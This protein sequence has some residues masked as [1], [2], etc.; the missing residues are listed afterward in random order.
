[1]DAVST[2]DAAPTLLPAVAPRGLA[3]ATIDRRLEFIEHISPRD[4]HVPLWRVPVSETEQVR[5]ASAAARH[6]LGEW[7]GWPRERR[8]ELLLTVAE[9][10]AADAPGLV[11]QIAIETGKPICDARQE[12][13]FAIALLRATARARDDADLGGGPGW[14]VRRRPQGVVAMITPWNN[15]LAIP[16]GKL[17]P[18]LLHGNTVVWKP[19]PAGAAVALQTLELLHQAGLPPGTVTLVQGNHVTAERLIADPTVDAVT[20]TGSSAAGR[21]AQR[22]CVARQVPF[23]GE[24]GGNNPAIV[25]SDANLADAAAQVAQGGFGSAGQRCTAN[26]RVIVDHDCYR[27]FLKALQKA[28]E[29]LT[30]G[31][32]LDDST[33]VGPV[34]SAEAL[35]RISGVVD[36]ARATGARVICVHRASGQAAELAER[37]CYYPPALVCCDD[38]AAEIVQ[39]ETFGPVIVVQRASGWGQA[40]KLCNGVS[41]GLVAALFSGSV[42]R[43]QRFLSEARAGLLKINASTAG[44]AAAAPFGGWKASGVGP[45]EHGVADVEFYTRFQTIY[46][47]ETIAN[48]RER[49][50][51][52]PPAI[53]GQD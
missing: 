39:E 14:T 21:A 47:N 33:Q 2:I 49:Q 50:A 9:R 25:W 16:L 31:D 22:L 13:I 43:Q 41:Q 12:L 30:W 26:R 10:V 11:R 27:A 29:A 7:A 53:P 35:C 24:L 42:E 45:A 38:P 46:Q 44:A 15:P 52:R 4:G 23:Q 32:P 18:A 5:A 51:V 17:A 48:G 19:A 36:R 20:L 34:I 1:M 3:D 6:A 8:S 28:T 40:M 37:G